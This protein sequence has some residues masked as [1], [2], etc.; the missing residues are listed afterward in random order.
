M[1][2]VAGNVEY[3]LHKALLVWIESR[4]NPSEPIHSSN[5]VC[6]A[7]CCVVYVYNA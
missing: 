3:V 5:W 4:E 7:I 2:S 1:L 6:L